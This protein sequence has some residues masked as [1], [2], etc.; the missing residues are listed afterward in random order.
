MQNIPPPNGK[1]DRLKRRR[2]LKAIG[3][4]IGAGWGA[5]W[6]KIAV[7]IAWLPWLVARVP[8]AIHTKL[9]V[10]FLAVVVLLVTVGVVGLQVLRE[11]NQRT[12]HVVALQQK[13]A[14]YRQLQQETTSQLYSVASVLFAPDEQGLETTLRQLNQFSYNFDR[15]Q[16]LAQG[17]V[18]LIGQIKHDHDQFREVVTQVIDLARA[19]KLTEARDL[20]LAQA[21]PLADDLERHMNQLVNKAEA[22]MVAEVNLNQQA[23]LKSQSAVIAF[24]LGSILLA[25]VLGYAI[26]WSLLGPVKQMEARLR[27][28]ASGDF[29]KQVKGL[30]RDGLGPVEANLNRMNDELGRLY[31]ELHKRNRELATT[32][33]ENVRLVSELEEKG[34]QLEAANHHKSEFL[35][36]MS[37][38]LRT[39]LN[40]IIGFS[41]FLLK[42]MFG[43]LN[44]NPP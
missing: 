16:F 32:L 11:A 43:E 6:A 34:R 21:T 25:L 12:E 15:L 41:K 39:P 24:A 10:A 38:E 36:N 8:A 37:H 23:Y 26:T 18:E 17:E 3:V 40:A 14:A 4:K 2:L 30:N 13:I 9:L 5:L 29:S 20:Q 28:I 44:E 7:R 27:E 1:G 31:E 35:A 42:K 19:G 22:D 33:D